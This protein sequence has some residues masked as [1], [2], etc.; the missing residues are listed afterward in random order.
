MHQGND[1]DENGLYELQSKVSEMARL[2]KRIQS[3]ML[4][5]CLIGAC[6]AFSNG[7]DRPTTSAQSD[8][9]DENGRDYFYNEVLPRFLENGCQACHT[10]GY[11]RPVVVIYEEV[12][13][14]LA[15]G[16]APESSMLLVTLADL[17]NTRTDRAAHVGG[18][19]CASLQVEPCKTVVEWW[20][21]E[22]GD[23]SMGE[24]P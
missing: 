9:E 21:L 15:M 6:I 20:R 3:P 14:F 24:S 4:S 12:F 23:G 5:V 7:C 19:R 10:T 1:G 2:L 13:P 11:V 17:R 18:N 8:S 22:F 16:D